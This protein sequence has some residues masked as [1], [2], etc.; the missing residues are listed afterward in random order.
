MVVISQRRE[1]AA[2]R[3][4]VSEYAAKIGQITTHRGTAGKIIAGEK[5]EVRLLLVDQLDGHI[6]AG[7][8]FVAIDVEVTDLASDYPF[9]AGGQMAH[10]KPD[11]NDIEL[12]DGAA[13]QAVKRTKRDRRFA[14]RPP[15]SR[16][17]AVIHGS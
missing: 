3:L 10:R 2:G 1:D 5:Y 12:V 11:R 15:P 7:Q 14:R 6:E 16:L 9:E 8:I 13:P 4:Q 17:A